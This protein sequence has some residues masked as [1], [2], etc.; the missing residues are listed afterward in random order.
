MSK[1]PNAEILTNW[2]LLTE[3]VIISYHIK[4]NL[5]FIL[6]RYDVVA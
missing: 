4:Q 3:M 5:K 2:S 1:R 6:V